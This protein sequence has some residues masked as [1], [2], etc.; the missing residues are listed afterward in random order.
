V[1]RTDRFRCGVP[2][3]LPAFRAGLGMHLRLNPG[4][5]KWVSPSKRE[6]PHA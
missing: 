3:K 6:A 1:V 4:A 2:K 5:T